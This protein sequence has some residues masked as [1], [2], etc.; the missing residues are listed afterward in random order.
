MV[1][2]GFADH[3]STVASAYA[4]F[5]PRYPAALF[6][7]LA[8]LAPQR[9]RVWDCATGSGQAAAVLAEHFERVIGA[10]AS[11]GQVAA[12][13]RDGAATER[14][15]LVAARAEHSGLRSASV[16]LVT[17]A[18][19]LHW[20]ATPAFFAEVR[21]VLR[22]GGLF[23]AWSYGPFSLDDPAVDD[24]LQDFARRVVGPFWPPER[25]LVDTG[26]RSIEIPMAEMSIDEAF[27]PDGLPTLDLDMTLPDLIGY[28]STWSATQ[29]ARAAAESDPLVELERELHTAWPTESGALR[30]EWPLAL[31]LARRSA[32]PAPIPSRPSPIEPTP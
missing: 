8:E 10:D 32:A 15:A 12:A 4:R 16:D 21:R 7:R 2:T 11:I 23:A 13:Q 29:R 19:A 3:F 5:R 25:R 1:T 9:G 27:A 20:F 6:D 26:Y 28:V 14:C 31:R 30:A 22:P 17:V 18:Q 24:L